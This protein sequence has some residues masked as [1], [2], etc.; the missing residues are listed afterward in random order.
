MGGIVKQPGTM[1]YKS[2]GIWAYRSPISTEGSAWP[3]QRA[4][5]TTVLGCNGPNWTVGTRVGSEEEAVVPRDSAEEQDSHSP[6]R[7]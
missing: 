4:E 1:W 5:E 2:L 6:P 3:K 7:W